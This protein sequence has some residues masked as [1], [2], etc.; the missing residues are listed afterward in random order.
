MS[1]PRLAQII[2]LKGSSPNRGA[3]IQFTIIVQGKVW[4][5]VLD[6]NQ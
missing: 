5:V 6:S 3:I 4:W 1:V 2:I